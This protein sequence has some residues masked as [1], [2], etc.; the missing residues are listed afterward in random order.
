M[1]LSGQRGMN[2]LSLDKSHKED[3]VHVQY[4]VSIINN[5][6]IGTPIEAKI[7][8][9]RT[10]PLIKKSEDYHMNITRFSVPMNSF[11]ISYFKIED[12]LAQSDPDRG[13]WKIQISNTVTNQTF[14]SNVTYIPQNVFMAAPKP[15]SSN[16][17]V[18]VA[19]KYYFVY[20]Y[21]N[22]CNMLNNTLG[23]LYNLAGFFTNIPTVIFEKG[24][25]S[26]V[27]YKDFVP[28]QLT[29]NNWGNLYFNNA[30]VTQCMGAIPYTWEYPGGFYKI[31]NNDNIYYDK[32]QFPNL[33]DPVTD[34]YN[35]MKITQTF[36]YAPQY[37]SFV[38]KIYIT[39]STLK[40][41]KLAIDSNAS[42]LVSPSIPIIFT[43][44][45]DTSSTGVSRD[46]LFYFNPNWDANN[47]I[48]LLGRDDIY[49]LD[50]QVYVQDN[51][52]QIWDLQI[53][54][55]ESV[56]IQLLFKKK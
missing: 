52:G 40:S 9:T 20:S 36:E 14:S 42:N 11:P 7:T 55:G 45:P 33:G 32:T 2:N 19:S 35:Y 43:F 5:Y 12:G 27:M 16:G 56:E 24:F 28:G 18:Q 49:S 38:R 25:F 39:S 17:G 4:S 26:I 8:T 46:K 21:E 50:F 3:D 53:E 13:I 30:L 22:I 48:D 41:R 1:K 54:Y 47:V 34:D 15:P 44:E 10:S 29:Y 51:Y 37:L 23:N 6:S 31:T